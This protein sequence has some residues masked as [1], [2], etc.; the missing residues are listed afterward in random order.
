[1]LIRRMPNIKINSTKKKINRT[2]QGKLKISCKHVQKIQRKAIIYIEGNW[3]FII[4]RTI[5]SIILGKIRKR[6][7][8][9]LHFGIIKE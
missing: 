7:E 1:M 2:N 9:K 8:R 6:C 3:K 4:Q 5:L